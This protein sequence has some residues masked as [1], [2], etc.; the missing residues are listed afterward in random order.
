HGSLDLDDSLL[1]GALNDSLH[2]RLT[3]DAIDD[4]RLS[5][6]TSTTD[7]GNLLIPSCDCPTTDSSDRLTSLD[8]SLNNL[9]RG[10]DRL[11]NDTNRLGRN[12]LLHDL[13]WSLTCESSSTPTDLRNN[14][15]SLD[16]TRTLAQLSE[17]GAGDDVAR[18]LH[19]DAE[20]WGVS[21]EGTTRLHHHLSSNPIMGP[22]L[23]LSHPLR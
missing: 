5:N 12:D 17:L 18:D 14:A 19:T 11:T 13:N 7:T 8:H 20:T 6:N 3:D 15:V 4:G 23:D 1:H 16:D 10:L 21:K 2:L 22:S 9:N